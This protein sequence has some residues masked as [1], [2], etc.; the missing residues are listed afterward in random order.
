MMQVWGYGPEILTRT[1]DVHLRRLR[2][3]LG[4]YSRQH[5]ETV[6]ALGYRFC[7]PS[8]GTPDAHAGSRRIG[9]QSIDPNRIV[10]RKRHCVRHMPLWDPLQRSPGVPGPAQ[11]YATPPVVVPLRPADEAENTSARDTIQQHFGRAHLDR[12][13]RWRGKARDEP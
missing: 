6:F 1:M 3:K 10:V 12:R 7:T 2:V 4:S 9:R 5:I 8:K 11:H 13:Q